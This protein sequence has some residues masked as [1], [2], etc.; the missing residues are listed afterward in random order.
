MAHVIV[1]LCCPSNIS[2]FP[3][4]FPSHTSRGCT[5]WWITWTTTAVIPA[6]FGRWDSETPGKWWWVSTCGDP[7]QICW[8]FQVYIHITYN[9]YIYIHIYLVGD[10]EPF[11]YF[12]IGNV[13]IPTVTHSY[14]SEGLV[15]TSN[16][17][18][19]GWFTQSDDPQATN[20]RYKHATF[21]TGEL[22]NWK[23]WPI[24]MIYED[25][26][27]IRRGWFSIALRERI[28]VHLCIY[29]YVQSIPWLNL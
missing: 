1:F 8:C 4:L 11:F 15:E 23:P 12:S 13:I 14:F 16:Q 28:K 5:A 6:M 18:V 21:W 29:G 7:F 27:W 3:R 19:M 24:E 10:L 17:N 26:S 20:I 22:A 25:L 9:I 2:G